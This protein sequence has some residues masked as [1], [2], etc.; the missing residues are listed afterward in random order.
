M[1]AVAEASEGEVTS[2]LAST[3]TAADCK[4]LLLFVMESSQRIALEPR[5]E[6]RPKPAEK[7]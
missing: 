6:V 3:L 4:E 1:H 7:E 2:Q 5:P